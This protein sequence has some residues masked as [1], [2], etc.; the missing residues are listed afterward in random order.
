MT[1]VAHQLEILQRIAAFSAQAYGHELTAWRI[2]EFSATAAC[3]KC[4]RTVTVHVSLLQP[5]IE[6]SALNAEC[7]AA[8]CGERS[9]GECSA[10]RAIR[11]NDGENTR[12]R[13]A[14]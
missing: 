3:S 5:D 8:E 6:G 13:H 4:R 1:G 12:Q 14:R 2:C 7:S 10:P 11:S 9:A